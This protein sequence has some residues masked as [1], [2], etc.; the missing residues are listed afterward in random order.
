MKGDVVDVLIV[1][2]EGVEE[3]EIARRPDLHQAIVAARGDGL[4]IRADGD[5][6]QP[7]LVGIHGVLGLRRLVG[8][9]PDQQLASVVAA[10]QLA[11]ARQER[12]AAHPAAVSGQRRL[13]LLIGKLPALDGV[14]LRGCEHEPSG[15]IEPAADQ[16]RVVP[17]FQRHAGAR[18]VNKRHAST[19]LIASACGSAIG[20]GRPSW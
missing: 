7:A 4:P 13:A 12:Q 6:P 14:V 5:G 3:R 11:L 8:T 2:S 18:R 20:I 19:S 16:G 17:Q 15:G 10:E 1:P 9:G